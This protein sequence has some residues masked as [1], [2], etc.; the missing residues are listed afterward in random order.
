MVSE[1]IEQTWTGI[2]RV[3]VLFDSY[4]HIHK[5]THILLRLICIQRTSLVLRQV[6]IPNTPP[7]D[8]QLGAK[9]KTNI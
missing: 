2:S 4:M 6:K 3:L 5:N 1:D 7:Y 8:M 9:Q